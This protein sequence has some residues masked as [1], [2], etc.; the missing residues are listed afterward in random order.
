MRKIT[1]P[2]YNIWN[3]QYSEVFR[4]VKLEIAIVKMAW[5]GKAD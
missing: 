2:D 1:R 5:K 3:A 4:C